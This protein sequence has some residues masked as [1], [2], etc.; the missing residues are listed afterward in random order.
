M[1]TF[2][3]LFIKSDIGFE[4]Q[5]EELASLLGMTLVRNE[6]GLWLNRNLPHGESVVGGEVHANNYSDPDSTAEDAQAFDGYD[7]VFAIRVL[8]RRSADQQAEALKIFDELATAR[9]QTPMILT[10]DLDL[11]VATYLPD[12]GAH[13][14]ADGVT[15]D[16]GDAQAWG[17]W[18]AA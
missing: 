15:V 8:P 10:H 1:A 4:A 13:V 7:T 16:A 11:V 17:P 2:E 5:A 12:R 14:F 18:V 3:H 9:P 6:Q